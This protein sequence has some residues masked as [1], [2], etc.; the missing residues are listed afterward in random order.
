MSDLKDRNIYPKVGFG[1]ICF[2]LYSEDVVNIIGSPEQSEVD[3][4]GD[5]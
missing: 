2:G 1:K 4:E 3:E 5:F